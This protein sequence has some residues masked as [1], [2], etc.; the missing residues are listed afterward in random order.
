L[1]AEGRILNGAEDAFYTWKR[2]RKAG[3]MLQ[4]PWYGNPRPVPL[5]SSEK[6]H[7]DKKEKLE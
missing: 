4:F 7:F 5:S 2:S 6:Q 1:L 3:R